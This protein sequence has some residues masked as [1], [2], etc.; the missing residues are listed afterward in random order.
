M[1][2]DQNE[3]KQKQIEEMTKIWAAAD[4]YGRGYLQGT[5]NA[6]IA[7]ADVKDKQPS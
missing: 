7:M 5:I 4:D 6:V 2:N 1:K 3:N